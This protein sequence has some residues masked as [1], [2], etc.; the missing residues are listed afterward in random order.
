MRYFCGQSIVSIATC[1]FLILP[2][3]SRAQECDWYAGGDE[4][5]YRYLEGR[6]TGYKMGPISRDPIN[7]ETV[8]FE[9]FVNDS[10]YADSTFLGSCF[11]AE[12]S[13]NLRLIL[14]SLPRLNKGVNH[15]CPPGARRMFTLTVK[16]T[17]YGIQ[18]DPAPVFVNSYPASYKFKWGILLVAVVSMCLVLF[19]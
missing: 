11:N 17:V 6:L 4:S 10:G 16:Q 14:A 12:L 13:N 7:G 19:R 8:S 5:F 3:F 18:V 1:F 9:I 2:S 15:G